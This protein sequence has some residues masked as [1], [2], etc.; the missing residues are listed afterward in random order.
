MNN[1]P[2]EPAPRFFEMVDGK[3]VLV[4]LSQRKPDGPWWY[5]FRVGARRVFESSSRHDLKEAGEWAR[6]VVQGAATAEKT[7][8][9]AKAAK[10]SVGAKEFR[11]LGDKKPVRVVLT[12]RKPGGLWWY[13]FWLQNRKVFRSSGSGSERE[14]RAAARQAVLSCFTKYPKDPDPNDGRQLAAARDAWLESEE[15]Q[16]CA[17]GQAE[18][19]FLR[20][21]LERAFIAGWKAAKEG[22]RE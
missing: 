11:V 20:N 2:P 1:I 13:S 18:G 7:V 6:K 4:R 8:Q 9:A 17:A 21:R 3:P 19:Q 22:E 10:V 5:S 16:T 14:A 12:R 15:G